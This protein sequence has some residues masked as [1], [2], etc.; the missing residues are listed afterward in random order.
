MGVVGHHDHDHDL[1]R[2]RELREFPYHLVEA[3]QLRPFGETRKSSEVSI[4]CRI[5]R[6]IV[7]Q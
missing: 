6:S 1:Y 2:V 5:H 3:L 7:E 4:T